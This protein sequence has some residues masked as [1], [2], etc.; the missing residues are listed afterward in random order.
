MSRRGGRDVDE[1]EDDLHDREFP[2]DIDTADGD[3]P[4]DIA[5][6]YCGEMISEDAERCPKC[7]DYIVEADAPRRRVPMWIII[8]A[9]VC[10]AVIL[11]TWPF[12]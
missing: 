1:D 6:P 5:C 2:D 8:A 10:L 9:V 7:G 4:A 12:I 11:L 3:E